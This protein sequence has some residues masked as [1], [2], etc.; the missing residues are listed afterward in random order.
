M[1]KTLLSL[2]PFILAILTLV[3]LWKTFDFPLEQYHSGEEKYPYSKGNEPIEVR[4][5]I[6][7]QLEFFEKG[8]MERD[9]NL[10]ESY[11]DR[12]ISR[13]TILI[14]G[15]MPNEI[16]SGYEAAADLIESDSLSVLSWS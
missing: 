1:K 11:C 15:T 9:T 2:F 7:T 10:L 16:Y 3:V 13:E 4:E 5:S 8:Y 12:L 14:L 6:S